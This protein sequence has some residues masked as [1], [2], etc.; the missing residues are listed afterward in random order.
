[1]QLSVK[2]YGDE[3]L[4]VCVCVIEKKTF[5]DEDINH[6]L[7]S[8]RPCRLKSADR[9]YSVCTRFGVRSWPTVR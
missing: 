9:L 6:D 7:G 5:N 2:L 1:M 4:Y 8:Q 3:S